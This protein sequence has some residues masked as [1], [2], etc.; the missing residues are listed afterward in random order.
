MTRPD[1]DHRTNHEPARMGPFLCRATYRSP[2]RV[3]LAVLTALCLGPVAAQAPSPT[4]G[5]CV[6]VFAPADLQSVYRGSAD[7]VT[8]ALGFAQVPL[9]PNE[10]PTPT[11]EHPGVAFM[12]PMTLSKEQ[13]AAFSAFRAKGGKVVCLGL[14]EQGVLDELKL[15]YSTP[16]APASQPVAIAADAAALPGGPQSLRQYAERVSEVSGEGGKVGAKYGDSGPA[17]VWLGE[18]VAAVGFTPTAG[19]RPGL[20]QLLLAILAVY[21][22][23]QAAASLGAMNSSFGI[24]G[25]FRGLGV[26]QAYVS[27]QKSDVAS[28]LLDAG[29]EAHR[30]ALLATQES[31]LAEAITRAVEAS[32]LAHRCLYALEKPEAN[33]IRAAFAAPPAPGRAGELLDTLRAGGMNAVFLYVGDALTAQYASQLITPAGTGDPLSDVVAAAG[34]SPGLDV[35]AWH[36]CFY[37]MGAP[38][39]QLAP[40]KDAGRLMLAGDSKPLDWL[41]L[42][43]EENLK[44]EEAI[45]TE[46]VTKYPVRGVV[47]D[48]LRFPSRSYCYCTS[49]RDAF[50][51]AHPGFG[52]AWPPIGGGDD[53]AFVKFRPEL[54]TRAV[55]RLA[56][57][58]HAA[59]PGALVIATA[60]GDDRT[61]VG[62]DVAAWLGD[63]GVD[64]LCPL[65]Y[66]QGTAELRTQLADFQLKT[67]GAALL[68]PGRSPMPPG[69]APSDPV[70]LLRDIATVRQARCDGLALYAFTP[71]SGRELAE[72]L[73]AGAYLGGTAPPYG[74]GPTTSIAPEPFPDVA[75]GSYPPAGNIAV[76]LALPG[77]SAGEVTIVGRSLDGP[78][79]N[80]VGKATLSQGGAD[81]TVALPPGVWR[82]YARG[83]AT[84][85]SGETPVFRSGPVL[86]VLNDK[87]WESAAAAAERAGRLDVAV[88]F[89]G[90]GAQSVYEELRVSLDPTSRVESI[91]RLAERELQGWD[92]LVISDPPD[93]KIITR[94]VAEM[95][96]LWVQDGGRLILLHNAIGHAGFPQIFLEIAGTFP[97][98]TVK[99][100]E[101]R[102]SDLKHPAAALLTGI[103]P[104]IKLESQEQ[105]L[106]RPNRPGVA[107][108]DTEPPGDPDKALAVA[109][110]Y[111][112]GRV[113]M[114]GIRLGQ[115]DAAEDAR[116]SRDES[117]L[118]VGL[119]KWATE[120]CVR[121]APRPADGGH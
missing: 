50:K 43:N 24:M 5:P 64:G 29:V 108:L 9:L 92:A 56:A 34:A 35:F 13:R 30:Q 113:V 2:L 61:S 59:R 28:R 11:P 3:A 53:V 91:E 51:A 73:G 99:A 1:P 116:L 49:C 76:H 45:L 63:G 70:D 101:A 93:P 89:P 17:A 66:T 67:R 109:S 41:C 4:P 114:C 74:P 81:A 69:Y 47:L 6:A 52:G 78:E 104:T 8:A 42:T 54:V 97:E 120:G 83:T 7:V 15:K 106:V 39:E 12:L 102:V 62:Q 96:R 22:P 33:E 57:A 14:Q 38:K 44:H 90:R 115:T 80:E 71:A 88:L 79:E 98:D 105:V 20:A 103:G 55:R 82:L 112:A 94:E 85:E 118:L 31:R 16:K 48:F 110:G 77:A 65:L 58:V 107:L 117:A 25:Q 26:L 36:A 27:Q 72:A 21:D 32:V 86:R 60:F 95:L 10:F 18:S 23:G 46:L 37:A 121:V 75:P 100:R 119:V 19:D 111:G 87:Q 84:L 40:L 68:V